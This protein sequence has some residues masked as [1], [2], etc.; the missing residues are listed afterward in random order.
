[1]AIEEMFTSLPVVTTAQM[2]DIICAVQGY[3]SPSVLG[4]S[5]QETL[6][7]VYNLFQSNVVL[8]Y[9]GN[10]NGNVAG[11]TFQFCWDTTDKILYI[12]TTSGT[13]S[14]AVW[15]E[16]STI[17]P[18]SFKLNS[19]TV[20]PTA[21]VT[22]NGYVQ[23]V[24]SLTTFV[25]PTTSNFGD[26]ISVIGSGNGGWIITQNALQSIRIGSSL[27]TPGTGGSIAS[28]NQYDAIELICITANLEWQVNAAP[29]GNLTI[30]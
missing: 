19:A 26:I 24:G 17:N 14:G 16:I 23:N 1:M 22:N 2:S 8:Y 29:Q 21:M 11:V 12:C 4:T 10:P 5:V 9:A 28:T 13:A 18:V 3:V 15:T 6:Q 25:L 30:V 27:S 7:Q 20:T